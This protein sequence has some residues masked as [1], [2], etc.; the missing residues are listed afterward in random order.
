MA[1]SNPITNEI[2]RWIDLEKR[3]EQTADETLVSAP[4]G[5]GDTML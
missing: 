4:S 3:A 1:P 2:D 5:Q